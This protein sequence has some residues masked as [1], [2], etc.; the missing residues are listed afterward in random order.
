MWKEL[1]KPELKVLIE[2]RDWGQLREATKNWTPQEIAE[3]LLDMEKSHRVLF[4]RSLDRK[5]SSDVF[6]Y[7]EPEDQDILL[8]EMTDQE[9]RQILSELDP[10][11][12]TALLEELPAQITKRM[13]EYLSPGDLKEARQLLGYPEESIGRIMTPDFVAIKPGRT[14][15]EA[16]S[17]I[18]ERGKDSET[19]NMI[20]V[21]DDSWKL[22]DDIR[23]RLFLLANPEDRVE[24]LMDYTAPKL[25]AFADR[26]QAVRKMQQY[27]LVAL[28]VV[29]SDNVLLGIVTVDDV[30][31][32][33]EE[34]TTEDIQKAASLAPLG[35]SYHNANI[36]TLYIK[37]IGWLVALVFMNIA[38]A[39]I[40]TA[41]E[42]TLTAAI[43]LAA[44]IPLL[45][46]SG[47]NT[48]SQSATLMIRA[49]VIGDVK[50]SHWGRTLLKE[51]GVGLL[52]GISLGIVSWGIGIIKGGYRVGLVVG[53][54]MVTIVL[55]ANTI[56]MILPFLLAKLKIDPA[57][58]SNPLMTTIADVTGLLIYFTFASMIL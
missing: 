7:R 27:D 32:I 12:R 51:I 58:A 16:L 30:M 47:G 14:I 35:M 13:M 2:N 11:D 43:G 29:D 42:Q 36:W 57:V 8:E 26:E 50:L 37:R 20:Y 44:F 1:L 17:K 15:G 56:G 38:A 23:L 21:V 31:D 54:T 39:G 5:V 25:S 48:G 24:S 33:A 28:P 41:H 3:L 49:L 18:R 40:I 52:L 45:I 34:E 4:F 22:L 6:S 10:D 9:T 55:V 46:G 53:L 19:I